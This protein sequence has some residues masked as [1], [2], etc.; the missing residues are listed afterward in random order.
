[1]CV[2]VCGWV[3]GGVGVGVCARARAH[4][5]STNIKNEAARAVVECSARK[6]KL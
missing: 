4:V 2:C 1:V 5:W 6:K 3:W